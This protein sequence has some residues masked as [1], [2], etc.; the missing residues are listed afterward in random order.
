MTFV[1]NIEK[2]RFNT[3]VREHEKGHFLQSYEWGLFKSQTEDWSFDA[4]GLESIS[5]EL[6]ATALV[7]IRYLPVVKRPILYIPRGFVL[8]YDDMDLLK[9]MTQAIKKYGKSKKAIFFKIDPDIK[10]VT[11][12]NEGEEMVGTD[13]KLIFNQLKKL[14]YQHLGFTQDFSS[15]IQPRYTM[16]LDLKQD[17]AAILKGMRATTR[18]AIK[19]AEKKGID[20]VRGTKDDLAAFSQLMQATSARA[21][22]IP[23]SLQYFESMYDLLAPAGMLTLYLGKL[24]PTQ[25]L[26]HISADLALTNKTI[27][28]YKEILANPKTGNKQRIKTENKL[29]EEEVKLP[30]L[31]AQYI[32]MDKLNCTGG[33]DQILTGA[34][35]IKFGNKV[36]YLYGASDDSKRDLKPNFLVQWQSMKDHKNDG[37]DIYDFFG[38]SGR[39]DKDDPV[40]GI[41][42]FKKGFGGEFTE[43]LG[44]F[45]YVLN[46]PL[47]LAWTK[48]MAIV[49][50]RRKK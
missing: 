33:A 38:I 10:Y 42:L 24:N 17:E 34:L 48:G 16:R 12:N 31:K 45:D 6:I 37:F 4:V 39:A 44:E 22:F 11:R 21:G 28:A 36:W 18:N 49:K 5:G 27:T 32:E 1:T 8:N 3:F 25:A 41:Y 7:L 30:N 29:K 14:G 26:A 9:T 50:K 47:Y 23:R 2:D 13:N 15:T 19:V 46:K 35:M 43:F 40:Y 20:V